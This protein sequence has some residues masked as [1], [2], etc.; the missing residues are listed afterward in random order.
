LIKSELLIVFN[1]KDIGSVA[2]SNNRLRVGLI[3][4][5]NTQDDNDGFCIFN[6]TAVQAFFHIAGHVC[7]CVIRFSA[8]VKFF[9][10]QKQPEEW[11]IPE[12]RSFALA[13]IDC[14]FAC[15]ASLF[16]LRVRFSWFEF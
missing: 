3:F 12:T 4:Q 1:T 7:I 13:F 6:R 16:I 10:L 15:L 8:F 2:F 14:V 5:G 9:F 11:H